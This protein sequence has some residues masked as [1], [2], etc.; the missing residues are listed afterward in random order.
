MQT[1]EPEQE[2]KQDKVESTGETE[3]EKASSSSEAPTAVKHDE[4]PESPVLTQV[5]IISFS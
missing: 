4:K 3:E 5:L 1:D 2:E